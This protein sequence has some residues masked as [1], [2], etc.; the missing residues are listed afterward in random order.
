MNQKYPKRNKIIQIKYINKLHMYIQMYIDNYIYY[1]SQP[2]DQLGLYIIERNMKINILLKNESKKN[3]YN[4]ILNQ[5]LMFILLLLFACLL[6]CLFA[7]LLAS[8]LVPLF[9]YWFFTCLLID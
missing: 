1:L 8:Q 2:K 9:A 5:L 7:Y 3:L 4:N 6:L